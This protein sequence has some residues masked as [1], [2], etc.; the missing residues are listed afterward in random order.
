MIFECVER[1]SMYFLFYISTSPS[2]VC[3]G[4]LPSA[5]DVG[6][7]N[8]HCLKPFFWVLLTKSIKYI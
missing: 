6:K 3:I 8:Q 4:D 5:Y 7:N 2:Y 1:G